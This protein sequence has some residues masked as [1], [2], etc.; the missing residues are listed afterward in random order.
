MCLIISNCLFA[1]LASAPVSETRYQWFWNPKGSSF[2][3]EPKK[4]KAQ[5]EAQTHNQHERKN[6]WKNG[7]DNR[8]M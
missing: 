6:D 2:N 3:A 4:E 7:E 5:F 8:F 1:L